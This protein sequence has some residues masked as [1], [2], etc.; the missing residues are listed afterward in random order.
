MWKFE[1]RRLIYNLIVVHP[2]PIFHENFLQEKFNFRVRHIRIS[3]LWVISKTG[4]YSNFILR[5]KRV[6]GGLPDT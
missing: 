6:G 5:N 4:I 2:K 1:Q 3:I